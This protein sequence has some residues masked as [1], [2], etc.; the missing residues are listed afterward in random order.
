M[1]IRRGIL[2]VTT[3]FAALLP[4]AAGN[5][6]TPNPITSSAELTASNGK[7]GDAM[8]SSVAISG[9]T[10]VMSGDCDRTSPNKYCN[11][12]HVGGMAYVF[13]RPQTGW[14][15]MTQVAE[16]TPSAATGYDGFGWAVAID[17]NTIVVG[18]PYENAA[19]VFVKPAAG[20]T[21]MT[22]TAK[23]SITGSGFAG[24]SVSVSGNTVVIGAADAE[25][26][27]AAYV[28]VEPAGGWTSSSQ[29]NAVLTASDAS[30]EAYLG[31]SVSIS[32]DTVVV[33]AMDT[34]TSLPGAAYV[35]VKPSGGWISATQT[36]ELTPSDGVAGESFG[37]SV[38]LDGDT[39]AVG[40]IGANGNLGSA[41]VFVRPSSGW[42]DMT[43]TAELSVSK[44]TENFGWAVATSGNMVLVGA[45]QQNELAYLFEKPATGWAST[46]APTVRLGATGAKLL[47]FSVGISGNASVVGTPYTTVNSNPIQGAAF[48]FGK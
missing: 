8:G 24:D 2:I 3:A 14:S 29:P 23:L 39:L 20:W 6:K 21:D 37:F 19:Y 48:V 34:Y 28:F 13:L 1:H 12:N 43:E 25:N 35:F 30:Q 4:E 22:E 41:Y 46:S 18:A 32:G 40:A 15:D 31:I 7:S 42:V 17:G 10:I 26:G 44:G 16:L 45:Y 38:S 9:N 27:G 11:I 5:A 47:G 33:G 36:A